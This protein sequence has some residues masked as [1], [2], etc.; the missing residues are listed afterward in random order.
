MN[1]TKRIL[2]W[3][4]VAAAAQPAL[5][6]SNGSNSSYSRFG[7]GT[8]NEQSQGFNRSMAGVAQGMA[9][10][11]IVNV[12]NPAS[13]SRIDSITFIFD[14]GMG[15]QFGRFSQNG[16][17]INARNTSFD[18][19]T[20]GFRLGKGLGMA[21]GFVPYSTIGYNFSTLS[22]IGSSLSTGQDITTTTTYYGNGGLHQ[23]FLGLGWNPFAHLSIG[24]N[25]GY[26][27]GSYNHSISQTYAEGGTT[28]SDYISQN[29]TWDSDVRTYKLDFGAQYPII[30][31]PQ[32]MLTLG[33]SVGLG[34]KIGS[35]VTIMRYTSA[36]DTVQDT[37]SKALEIP[38]TFS[39]G[40][41]W[42]HKGRLTL[43]A[44]Y[45]QQRWEGCR[46]PVASTIN[47]IPQIDVRTDQYLIRH[48]VKVGAEYRKDPTGTD[49]RYANKIKF[50]IGAQYTTPYTRVNGV[51]GPTE[52]GV[53]AG[54]ALPIT[55]S[56]R[57]VAN[58]GVEWKHRKPSIS[59]QITE[60]YLMLHLGVTF[61]EYW[62]MKRK[63]R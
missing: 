31:N 26:M 29:I 19:A 17:N 13:Y 20:A 51:D 46:I 37:R 34:H 57:S 60:N 53:T 4:L 55:Q 63:F 52:Y 61:S 49:K 54:A 39:V 11:Q 30:L 62:F 8:L 28:S 2:L 38:L 12:Q 23:M 33:A 48:Q 59:T 10:G 50:R 58:I 27:W 14:V 21:I 44:D 6:Q 22:R 32:N 24:V 16:N 15:M 43:A 56:G 3:I 42:Q 1:L 35:D 18:Y 40:A 5:A 45:Q 47:G 7:L 41:T 25:A 9:D 36:R